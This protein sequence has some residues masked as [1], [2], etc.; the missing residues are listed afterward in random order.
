M[1]HKEIAIRVYQ[2]IGAELNTEKMISN[3]WHK[4][5]LGTIRRSYQQWKKTITDNGSAIGKVYVYF[6]YGD[7]SHVNVFIFGVHK[8]FNIR[9]GELKEA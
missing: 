9:N 3:G 4:V 7:L 1:N 6:W 5:D 8:S 2:E